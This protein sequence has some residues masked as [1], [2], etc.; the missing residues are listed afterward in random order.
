MASS[1]TNT[2]MNLAGRWLSREKAARKT[3]WS[4][5]N[6]IR[7]EVRPAD[8]ILIHGHSRV[9]KIIA[10]ITQSQWTH[11]ALYVGRLYDISDLSLREKLQNTGNF[12]YDTQMIIESELGV[13]TIVSLLDKYENKHIRILRPEWVTD[14]D[15]QQV[16][17]HAA[18]RVG[19][20]YNIRQIL[21]LARLLFPWGIFPRRWRSSLFQSN[22]L[23]PT[24]DI[25]ST[26]IAQAFQSVG[27]PILPEIEFN[28]SKQATFI[29]RNVRLF[30]PSD[31]DF[32]P[33]FSV[34]KYPMFP[35]NKTGNYANI[36]WRSDMVSHGNGQ[37]TTTYGRSLKSISPQ[38]QR[39]LSSPAFA[40]VGASP[41]QSKYGN[42]ILKC[43]LAKD[44]IVFPVNPSH[45][46]IEDRKC[47]ASIQEL[48]NTVQSISIVTP[49]EITEGLIDIA[50]A[51]GI[52]NIWMQPGTDSPLAV[53][54]CIKS[55]INVI[56]HG[57][58]ILVELG[59]A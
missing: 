21:D 35:N 10:S 48:P 11:A 7:Q 25:C 34:I 30:T 4:D 29:R 18:S 28:Q 43:Y 46:I 32:S 20:E 12:Q 55:N 9:S 16:I 27:Y 41:N 53:Q 23:Q 56:A 44:K 33:Y 14:E 52:R 5:F 45:K 6:K 1:L 26:V 37:H 42:K 17:S 24:K 8:I 19:R 39:F 50:I 2:I 59:C 13:G 51:K 36:K 47:F 38:I 54:K 3:Y 57:P 49:P 31:F 40:V 22:A 15:I 58:C